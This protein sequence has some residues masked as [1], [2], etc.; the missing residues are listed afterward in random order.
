VDIPQDPE[1]F[2]DVEKGEEL[3]RRFNLT[4]LT[5]NNKNTKVFGY[6]FHE[7]KII[8]RVLESTS[9]SLHPIKKPMEDISINGGVA[10]EG[11]DLLLLATDKGLLIVDLKEN[12]SLGFV[13]QTENLVTYS[14]VVLSDGSIAFFQ[15]RSQPGDPNIDVRVIHTKGNY[16]NERVVSEAASAT[17][18]TGT[19]LTKNAFTDNVTYSSVSIVGGNYQVLW[20]DGKTVINIPV[21]PPSKSSPQIIISTSS[22]LFS[23]FFGVTDL[24]IQAVDKVSQSSTE[25]KIS[26]LT[27]GTS[28]ISSS[29]RPYVPQLN[30]SG[31]VPLVE[32]DYLL[33]ATDRGLLLVNLKTDEVVDFVAGSEDYITKDLLELPDGKISYLQKTHTSDNWEL[34]IIQLPPEASVQLPLSGGTETKLN[35]EGPQTF[36]TSWAEIKKEHLDF[37]KISFPPGGEK[38]TLGSPQTEEGRSDDENQREVLFDEEYEIQT[39]LVTQGLYQKVMGNNPSSYKGD[40]NRPVENV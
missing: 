11:S 10:L 36:Q 7:D 27:R 24:I 20:R 40:L 3:T 38:F 17:M 12:K 21:T 25:H 14:P 6:A 28:F 34:R 29:G 5:A 19:E 39:T 4:F 32:G 22:Q 31:A 33:F 15:K 9:I 37:A 13:A 26:L 8:I 16:I 23:C 30:V 18:S 35:T 2:I 1:F